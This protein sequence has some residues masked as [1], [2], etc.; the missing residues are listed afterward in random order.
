[1]NL[2]KKKELALRNNMGII[3]IVLKDKYKESD[4][5]KISHIIESSSISF[6]NLKGEK[7]TVD[8]ENKY[9]KGDWVLPIIQKHMTYKKSIF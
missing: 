3:D 9:I 2:A 5:E 4:Y 8:N 6:S 7:F 1:L